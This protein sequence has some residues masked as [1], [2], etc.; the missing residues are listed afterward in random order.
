MTYDNME[1][2]MLLKQVYQGLLEVQLYSAT[3]EE[4]DKEDW[5]MTEKELQTIEDAIDII[6][7]LRAYEE[8]EDSMEE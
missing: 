6:Y 5:V 8:T 7:E 3:P 1:D 4:A 2:E